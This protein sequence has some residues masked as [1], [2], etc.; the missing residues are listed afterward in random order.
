MTAPDPTPSSPSPVFDILRVYLKDLSLEQPA[1]NGTVQLTQE[2]EINVRIEVGRQALEEN[3]GHFEVFVRGHLHATFKAPAVQNPDQN[4]ADTQDAEKTL[5]LVEAKQAGIFRALHFSAAD[6]EQLLEVNCPHILFP[7][8]R[9]ALAN[10]IMNAGFPPI[11]LAEVNFQAL[12]AQRKARQN[13]PE[14]QAQPAA[15]ASQGS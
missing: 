1:P 11:Q 15:Q 4:A 7:Y 2:P 9:S 14:G 10:A 12:W 3:S 8:L 5:F 13:A 6:L